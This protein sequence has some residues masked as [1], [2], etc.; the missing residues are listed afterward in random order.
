MRPDPQAARQARVQRTPLP[1]GD[2]GAREQPPH[3]H[4]QQG[5][6]TLVCL[7]RLGDDQFVLLRRKGAGG[8]DDAPA[9]SAQLH[10]LAQQGA[11]TRRHARVALGTDAKRQAAIT[12]QRALAGT[13]RVDQDAIE[14]AGGGG[15]VAAVAPGGGAIDDA[16]PV[17]I[18]LQRGQTLRREVIGQQRAAVAER[19]PDLRGLAAGRRAQVQ[20]ALP[21]PQV[22]Q[23]D[24]QLRD[25][26]LRVRQ[27]GAVPPALPGLEAGRQAK[28]AALGGGGKR[29]TDSGVVRSNVSSSGQASGRRRIQPGDRLGIDPLLRDQRRQVHPVDAGRVAP[30]AGRQRPHQRIDEAIPVIDPIAEQRTVA[31]KRYLQIGPGRII[32]ISIA[33]CHVLLSP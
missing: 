32:A 10:G 23:R 7:Q 1:M 3:R 6:P 9:R 8:V 19:E 21:G 29:R 31:A 25:F 16:E 15:I 33:T 12:P 14:R 30:E 18:A 2:A 24:G 27:A 22:Q 28:G 26:L 17:Q 20:H 5:Q 13:G 11:L 4:R